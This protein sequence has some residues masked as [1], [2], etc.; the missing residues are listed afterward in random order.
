M[1]IKKDFPGQ[2]KKKK[3]QTFPNTVILADI[4]Y[5]DTSWKFHLSWS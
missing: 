3:V 2:K 1:V 4:S 5:P